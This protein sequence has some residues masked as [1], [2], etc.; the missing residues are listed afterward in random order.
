VRSNPINN[1]N[2]LL[3][4]HVFV[5]DVDALFTD[6]MLQVLSKTDWSAMAAVDE[7]TNGWSTQPAAATSDLAGL[8]NHR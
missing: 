1:L 3:S 6:P 2:Y 7:I 5:V 4:S 8:V